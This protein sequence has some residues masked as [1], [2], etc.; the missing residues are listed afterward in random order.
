MILRDSML[1]L[2][3]LLLPIIKIVTTHIILYYYLLQY[4]YVV[5]VT[6]LHVLV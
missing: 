4:S 5:L 3:Y 2:I 6:Q 1:D